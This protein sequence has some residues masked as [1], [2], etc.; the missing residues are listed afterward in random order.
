MRKNSFSMQE[1]INYWKLLADR[2]VI[3]FFVHFSGLKCSFVCSICLGQTCS[4]AI[5]SDV[6]GEDDMFEDLEERVA[7]PNQLPNLGMKIRVPYIVN[8][9]IKIKIVCDG[10]I[11]KF[12]SP[13]EKVIHWINDRC[14]PLCHFFSFWLTYVTLQSVISIP[15]EKVDKSLQEVIFLTNFSQVNSLKT[16]F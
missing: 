1:L 13:L 9:K 4:N 11:R 14:P 6:I 15:V 16:P 8:V 3:K 12:F 2:S 5:P 10:V 7:T